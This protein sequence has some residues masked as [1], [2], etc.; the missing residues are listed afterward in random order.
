MPNASLPYSLP[1]G[2]RQGPVLWYVV[3]IRADIYCPPGMTGQ[4]V[5]SADNSGQTA[6]QI[7]FTV[8]PNAIVTD[9]LGFI[10]G[11]R[12]RT[13]TQRHV[14]I[15]FAN[16]SQLTGV[17]PGG[18]VLHFQ[19]ET[20]GTGPKRTG[21]DS[22][23]TVTIARGSG[24]EATTINPYELELTPIHQRVVGTVG[25]DIVVPFRLRRR[26]GRPDVAQG[27]TATIDNP[28]FTVRGSQV[29]Y[30][31]IGRERLGEFTVR[32]KHPGVGTVLLRAS[33]NYNQP[34]AVVQVVAAPARRSVSW[35]G[36]TVV[37]VI[38]CGGVAGYVIRR[39]GH[40]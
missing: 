33:D 36:L 20:L 24:I 39:R 16:Y 35:L 26:G 21:L 5:L 3:A 15:D 8:T 32:A 9:E 7:N 6:A 4:Y 17:R 27:V 2:A 22:G 37:G 25:S 29:K 23:P 12:V 40:R 1:A 18:N 11:H 34:S 10:T 30:Q 19:F 31:S 38:F 14:T 13:W 28:D